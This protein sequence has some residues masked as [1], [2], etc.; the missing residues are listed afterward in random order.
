MA[1]LIAG[2]AVLGAVCVYGLWLAW[3]LGRKFKPLPPP[4]KEATRYNTPGAV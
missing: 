2:G 4:T 3:K 1:G